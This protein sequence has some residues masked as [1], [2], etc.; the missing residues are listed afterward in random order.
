MQ[1]LSSTLLAI[2]TWRPPSDTSPQPVGRNYRLTRTLSTGQSD[3]QKETPPDL[4][5]G[6]TVPIRLLF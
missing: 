4:P 6:S 2:L 1:R 3:R 5:E